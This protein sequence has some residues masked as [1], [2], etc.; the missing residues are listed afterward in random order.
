MQLVEIKKYSLFTHSDLIAQ[1]VGKSHDSVIKLI[2]R[3]I[4]DLNEFGP[5]GFE[6]RMANRIQGGGKSI[7]VATLN[8]EQATLLI[9]Y[10]RNNEKVRLFKKLLVKEFFKM[11]DVLHKKANDRRFA[12]VEYR[13]MTDAIK[14][15]KESQGKTIKHYHFSNEADLI[16]RIALGMT[17]AKFRVFHDLSKKDPI[18]DYLTPYQLKC[19]TDLQRANTAFIQMG[20]DFDERKDKLTA[21][22]K[23]NHELP[24]IKEQ[25]QLAA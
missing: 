20:L 19:V 15:E 6:I 2:D 7:R 24:L 8:E 21:M 18:R 14:H 4:E 10:M 5:V 12:K 13:P 9:T 11:R 22:Y 25:H 3:N 1:G 17:S 23:R 16:N